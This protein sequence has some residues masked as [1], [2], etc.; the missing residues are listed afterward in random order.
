MNSFFQLEKVIELVSACVCVCVAGE[1]SGGQRTVKHQG[2][3][4]KMLGKTSGSNNVAFQASLRNILGP[5]GTFQFVSLCFQ[6]TRSLIQPKT[7]KM[8]HD[9]LQ[10]ENR[11]LYPNTIFLQAVCPNC[12]QIYYPW[13]SQMLERTGRNL[14]NLKIPKASKPK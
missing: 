12:E 5:N 8:C 10:V 13:H 3:K 11:I 9:L 7:I 2:W 4:T 14:K 1:G 6:F